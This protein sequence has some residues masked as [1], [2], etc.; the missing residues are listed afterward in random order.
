VATTFSVAWVVWLFISWLPTYL[1]HTF[2][3]SLRDAGIYSAMPFVANTIGGIAA[4]WMQDWLISRGVSITKVRRRTLTAAFLGTMSFLFLIPNAP[5]AMHAV[6]YLTGAMGIFAAA[7]G[8]V[9]VNN[10]DIAP[11]HAG[12]ILGLQATA[13]NV[14]GAISPLVAGFIVLRTGSFDAVFYL[15]VALLAVTLIVWNWLAR[16]EKV[17]E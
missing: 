3:F 7:Q 9:M 1:I 5:T 2:D 10:M 11:R 12:V 8:T 17:I 6:W 4:A 14:A 16:G 15:I 13:G